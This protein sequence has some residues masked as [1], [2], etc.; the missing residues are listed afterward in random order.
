M[1]QL[2]PLRATWLV[3]IRAREVTNGRRAIVSI[4]EEGHV[5]LRRFAAE[6]VGTF[7]LVLFAVGAAVGG[8]ERIGPVGVALAFGFVLLALCDLC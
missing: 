1:T 8:I 2:S 3:T 6:L 4:I 5:M 7:A